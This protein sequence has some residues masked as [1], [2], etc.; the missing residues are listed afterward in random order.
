M[1]LVGLT[2]ATLAYVVSDHIRE[3]AIDSSVTADGALI[4]SFAAQ[5][6]AGGDLGAPAPP[7][8]TAA[9]NS[10]LASLVDPDGSG[11]VQLKIYSADD[12][13]RFSNDPSLVGRFSG[14][15]SDLAQAIYTGRPVA[16]IEPAA[17]GEQ[18]TVERGGNVLEE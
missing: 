15:D 16:G 1:A 9:I 5:V 7:D 17:E 2:S 8:R 14:D 6:G 4:L 10:G 18:A 12:H 11:I 3:S 13:I